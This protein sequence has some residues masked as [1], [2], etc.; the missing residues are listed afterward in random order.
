M[1]VPASV[2]SADPALF[3]DT[4]LFA[5]CAREATTELVEAQVCI[6]E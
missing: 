1:L 3:H 6:D 5:V 2:I 4:S